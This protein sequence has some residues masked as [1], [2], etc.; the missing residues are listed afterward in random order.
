MFGGIKNSQR[1]RLEKKINIYNQF[2][3]AQAT[4][5]AIFMLME[6]IIEL[7]PRRDIFMMEMFMSVLFLVSII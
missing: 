2:R 1:D 5:W 3:L 6:T 7:S 4:A